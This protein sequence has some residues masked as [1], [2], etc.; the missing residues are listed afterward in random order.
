MVF[1]KMVHTEYQ[2]NHKTQSLFLGQGV[3]SS[4]QNSNPSWA[5]SWHHPVGAN[6]Y[7]PFRHSTQNQV[8]IITLDF[9]FFAEIRLEITT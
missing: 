8:F 7:P 2:V 5:F 1:L 3:S 6:N 9:P 4:T